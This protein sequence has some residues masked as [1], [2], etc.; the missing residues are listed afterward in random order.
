MDA[1]ELE[2]VEEWRKELATEKNQL[3]REFDE[4]ESGVKLLNAK[5]LIASR[6]SVNVGFGK[7]NDFQEE[8]IQPLENELDRLEEKFEENRESSDKRYKY[9][10][11]LLEEIDKT[12]PKKTERPKL[13]I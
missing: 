11:A 5:I 10:I 6:A 4:Y 1:K 2:L 3:R 7:R 12:L 13:T 8:V 9:V